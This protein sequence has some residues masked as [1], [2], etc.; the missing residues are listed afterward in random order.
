MLFEIFEDMVQILLMLKVLFTQDGK[1]E[2]LFCGDSTSSQPSLFFSNQHD[3]TWVTDE[4][5]HQMVP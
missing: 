3:F 1:V 4:V 5:N 2:D